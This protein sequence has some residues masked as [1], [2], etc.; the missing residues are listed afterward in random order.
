[1][2]G[3]ATH[4]HHTALPPWPEPLPPGL[5]RSPLEPRPLSHTRS[6][7]HFSVPCLPPHLA[8]LSPAPS[9]MYATIA[10]SREPGNAIMAPP[11]TMPT[12]P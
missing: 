11:G 6:V 5:E 10:Y 12:T 8:P 4:K 3:S 7:P 1:M 2:L 9:G